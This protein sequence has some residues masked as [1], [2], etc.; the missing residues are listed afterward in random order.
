M[1]QP[2]GSSSIP[3]RLARRLAVIGA[4]SALGSALGLTAVIVG[5]GPAMAGCTPGSSGSQSDHPNGSSYQA[6]TT[7]CPQQLQNTHPAAYDPNAQI[8]VYVTPPTSQDPVY[9]T[10]TAPAGAKPGGANMN[11]LCGRAADVNAALG[12]ADPSTM[13]QCL[14]IYGVWV[15]RP[16]PSPR[17]IA[18]S[19]ISRLNL[20]K[21]QIHTNP[22]AAHHLVVSLPTWLWIDG[23]TGHQHAADP[24]GRVTIDAR[25]TVAWSTDEGTGPCSGPGTP[26]VAGKSDPSAIPDCGWTFRQAGQHTITADA[27][28]TVSFSVGGVVQGQLAPTRW[29]LTQPVLVDEIQ[30]V[31]NGG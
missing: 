21:P 4:T 11:E 26:Y 25:Q 9:N 3:Q 24:T 16:P 27:T 15:N 22:D 12:T 7:T 8:C 17:Q 6:G 28:W 14:M 10:A 5:A 23:Q 19:L 13:C 31:N 20:G 18:Q 30:T 29:T 2:V 1:R